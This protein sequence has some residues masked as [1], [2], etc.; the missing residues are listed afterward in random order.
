MNVAEIRPTLEQIQW[1]DCEIGVIIH[2]DLIIYQA[3][4]DSRHHFGDPIPASVFDPKNL[5]TDQWIRAAKSL[6]AKYAILVAKHG[7][8]FSLWPTQAHD[9]S[10]KNSPYKKRSRRHCKGFY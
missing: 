7:T 9:Y 5:D 3:P 8:G 4:Y 2:F 1:A 10:V 6:G